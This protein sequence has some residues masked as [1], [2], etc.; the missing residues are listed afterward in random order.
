MKKT[1]LLL[2]ALALLASCEQPTD[3]GPGNGDTNKI[4]FTVKNESSYDLA[5]VKW[6]DVSF[7]SSDASDLLKATSSTKEVKENDTGYIRFT[8]KD[9]SIELR[10][11]ATY[12][13]SDS[14]ATITDNTLVIEVGNDSNRGILKEI[15]LQPN[16]TVERNALQVAKNDVVNIDES[17]TN[18]PKQIQFS[19]KNTG[20][21]TLTFTGNAP[22]KSSDPAFTVIQPTSSTIVSGASLEFT[23]T[24]NPTEEKTY[25]TTITIASNDK[26][27]DFTFTVSG[28]GVSPKPIVNI[29]YNGAEIAQDGPIDAGDVILTLSKKADITIRNSGAILLTLDI[30]AISIT[31]T[32]GTDSAAFSLATLPNPNISA[33][34]GESIFSIQCVPTKA[35]ENSA[36]VSIPTNDPSRN[37]VVFYIKVTGTPV[38]PP[39]GLSNSSVTSDSI[40]LS[41]DAVAGA[42]EYFVYRGTSTNGTYTKITTSDLATTSYTDTGLSAGTTYYYKVSA[43]NSAGE[44][45]QSAYISATT[46]LALPAAPTVVTAIAASSTSITVSW[47]AV[48]GTMGYFVYRST[49]S[50]GAYTKIT[51]SAVT[52]TSY[53]DTEL[54]GGTTY[55]YKVSATNSVGEGTQSTYTYATTSIAAPTGVTATAT[56]ST[57]ITVSWNTVIGASKYKI[58]RASASAGPYLEIGENT[59][60]H[61][62]DSDTNLIADTYYY[63]RLT[64]C[65]S[66]GI[67]SDKSPYCNV[68]TKVVPTPAGLIISADTAS[69]ITLLWNA[70]AEAVSYKIYRA[71]SQN[72]G[73]IPDSPSYYT[74]IGS[75]NTTTYTDTSLQSPGAG[76]GNFY[77]YKVSAINRNGSESPLSS[78]SSG[79]NRK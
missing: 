14:S 36:K 2:T 70:A 3:D 64:A 78:Y 28:N 26:A 59:A 39:T 25:T 66:S 31:D 50:G 60:V 19:I 22:V 65:D 79:V 38:A 56:S 62:I 46:L 21:G 18:T 34:G 51:T 17:I 8:R 37:P 16:L 23:L 48:S 27:G 29:L 69:G 43:S 4:T 57:S 52:T 63:Y 20:K 7:A 54:S 11:E 76:Y 53:T 74:E 33:N 35:G 72:A 73:F 42:S 30:N 44:G 9:I 77:Y 49:S 10:T 55:Y 75:S 41:W 45:A 15:A 47:D 67:E 6:A 58:Y 71:M 32:D 40:T 1:F 68:Q 5:A 12:S 13:Q 24:F 61:Y